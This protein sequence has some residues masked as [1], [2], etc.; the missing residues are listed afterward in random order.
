[1][2]PHLKEMLILY[3]GISW[4]W[5][6]NYFAILGHDKIFGTDQRGKHDNINRTAGLYEDKYCRIYLKPHKQCP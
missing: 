3:K 4:K 5:V 1:M 2:S 6:E